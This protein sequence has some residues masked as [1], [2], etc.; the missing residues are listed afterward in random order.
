M[1]SFHLFFVARTFWQAAALVGLSHL[2]VL[3]IGVLMPQPPSLGDY[4]LLEMKLLTLL[5]YLPATLLVLRRPNEGPVPTWLERRLKS[6]PAW[7]RGI[8]A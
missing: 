7:L 2:E 8:P 1:K 3:L 4:L 5:L 6:W